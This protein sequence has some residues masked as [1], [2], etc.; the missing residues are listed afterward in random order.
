MAGYTR[1]VSQQQR[2]LSSAEAMLSRIQQ[3]A[4]AVQDDRIT[5]GEAVEHILDELQA[6]PVLGRVREALGYARELSRPH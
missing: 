2:A 4:E 6:R 1:N 5:A 3:S